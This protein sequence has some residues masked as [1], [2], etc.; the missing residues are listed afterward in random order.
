MK[1]Q[2]N[3]HTA[4]GRIKSVHGVGQPPICNASF[5]MFHYLTEAG[6]PF[7]RLH[8]VGGA[9]GEFRWVDVPN[10][11]RDFN[12]VIRNRGLPSW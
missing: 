5:A 10:I 6:I 1:I 4:V 12:G 8:D 2:A 9:Y 11:F 7:S 3:L